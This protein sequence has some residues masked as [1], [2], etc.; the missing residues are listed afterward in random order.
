MARQK[1]QVFQ[2]PTG[3]LAVAGRGKVF[4]IHHASVGERVTSY[5]RSRLEWPLAAFPTGPGIA[6]ERLE[7]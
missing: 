6:G 7:T 5:V 4:R 2:L 1:R 3:R